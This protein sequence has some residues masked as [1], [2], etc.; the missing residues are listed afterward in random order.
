M[1]TSTDHAI[2]PTSE[3]LAY[4]HEHGLRE[5]VS[6]DVI[7]AVIFDRTMGDAVAQAFED[8]RLDIIQAVI[9]Q[10][11]AQALAVGFRAG[12]VQGSA[13]ARRSTFRR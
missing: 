1:E 8:G 13:D 11:V 3:A 5:H 2:T 7:E 12:H 6:P 9:G 10:A 4:A